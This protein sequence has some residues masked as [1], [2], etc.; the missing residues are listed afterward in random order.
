MPPRR[1]Q[2]RGKG[3]SAGS[4]RRAN[5]GPDSDVPQ[6]HTPEI[7][8]E[9]DPALQTVPTW[10]PDPKPE[11]VHDDA[12][13][14]VG[15]PCVVC[16]EE[17]QYFCIGV[18][19]HR[20]VC[21]NCSL[22]LRGLLENK[23][24]PQC[25]TDCPEVAYTSQWDVI[26]DFDTDFGNSKLKNSYFHDSRLGIWYQNK[27]LRNECEANFDFVCTKCQESN[28]AVI[29]STLQDLKKHLNREH[30]LFLCDL[31]VGHIKIFPCEYRY[32]SKQDLTRHRKKG[33]PDDASMK[34]HSFC[35][36]C[37]RYYFDNDDL[38][39]HLRKQ[40]ESCHLC[41]RN[42]V[43]NQYYKNYA[44]LEN[45]F[46][47]DHFLCKERDCL[48]KKFVVFDSEIDF[49]AH[50]AQEHGRAM[51]RAAKKQAVK[52]DVQFNYG[53]GSSGSASPRNERSNRRQGGGDRSRGVR[54]GGQAQRSRS[55]DNLESGPQG[56]AEDFEEELNSGPQATSNLALA[57]TNNSQGGL[58][59]AAFPG[60]A[61]NSRSGSGKS[62]STRWASAA[63]GSM[64]SRGAEFPELGSGR[65]NSP[66]P[67]ANIRLGNWGH[68]Q[69]RQ[70]TAANRRVD[71]RLMFGSNPVVRK[72]RPVPQR[73]PAPQ[74]PPSRQPEEAFPTLGGGPSTSPS[75]S[76]LPGGSASQSEIPRDVA[77]NVAQNLPKYELPP[78]LKERNANMIAGIKAALGGDGYRFQ[79][80]KEDGALFRSGE[81]DADEFYDRFVGLVP[82][83][84][85]GLYSELV[86]M[87]PDPD[88]QEELLRAREKAKIAQKQRE[89]AEVLAAA[90]RWAG[91]NVKMG[92]QRGK[93]ANRGA[94]KQQSAWSGENEFKPCKTCGV[95]VRMRDMVRHGEKYHRGQGKQDFPSLSDMRTHL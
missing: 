51:D 70:V 91:A 30:E 79:A 35:K 73:R 59:E 5:T 93:H 77:P 32:Y 86:E 69:H 54:A 58:S 39:D 36:F 94:V 50:Q 17:M 85:H 49:K 25:R 12:E 37:S 34:G 14:G 21:H 66:R 68:A 55:I 46:D 80:F 63:G 74:A 18:C 19:N 60:L 88:K 65:S 76:S 84:S 81:I 22:R 38:F 15:S 75:R 8:T 83:S 26:K 41:R 28:N 6:T 44:D 13:V 64:G 10:K 24:C 23:S 29:C 67:N 45:H 95:Q 16:G 20:V 56:V 9:Q 72:T 33:D 78:E 48:E 11:T 71:H 40:H 47:S 2:G 92:K 57:Q 90:T 87:M 27:S 1:R 31:C 89:D 7:S 61:A 3:V 43:M 42:G 82:R 52:L 4:S 53:G 62:S